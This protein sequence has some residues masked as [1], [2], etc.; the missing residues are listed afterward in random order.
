MS[1]EIKEEK[2]DYSKMTAIQIV[3]KNKSLVNHIV[4]DVKNLEKDIEDGK[5]LMETY[6]SEADGHQETAETMTCVHHSENVMFNI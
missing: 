3:N 6:I 1:Q 4:K 2:E 5:N